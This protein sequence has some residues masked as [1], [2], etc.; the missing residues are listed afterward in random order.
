[1]KKQAHQ[2]Y[3]TTHTFEVSSHYI[4]VISHLVLC[5]SKLNITLQ[6]K[7]KLSNWRA[8]GI[9]FT[10]AWGKRSRRYSKY[11]S[12]PKN[13]HRYWHEDRSCAAAGTH[14]G[15]AE[16]ANIIADRVKSASEFMNIHKTFSLHQ[17]SWHV[18]LLYSE[19]SLVCSAHALNYSLLTNLPTTRTFTYISRTSS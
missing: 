17:S 14:S 11:S 19:K 2:K 5:L 7:S 12:I 6:Y 18:T 8:S 16:E 1:M 10:R 3:L 13:C 9:D 15:T 4:I